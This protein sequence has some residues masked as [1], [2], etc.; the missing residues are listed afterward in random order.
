M[1]WLRGRV[2]FHLSAIRLFLEQQAE[3]ARYNDNR[4]DAEPYL[5]RAYLDNDVVAAIAG[6][7][8]IRL[9]GHGGAP[10]SIKTESA[11]GQKDVGT[12]AEGVQEG[13][14]VQQLLVS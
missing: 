13:K 1:V 4:Y 2:R 7:I 9:E 12:D 8:A 6:G 11:R 10:L 14:S 3:Q 5:H